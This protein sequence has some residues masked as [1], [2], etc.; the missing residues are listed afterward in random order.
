MCS[1]KSI[2][3]A[4]AIKTGAKSLAA[5]MQTLRR[6]PQGLSPPPI[7]DRTYLDQF[8]PDTAIAAEFHDPGR[9]YKDRSYTST[10][11]KREVSGGKFPGRIR[12]DL[13][14]IASEF[15]DPRRSEIGLIHRRNPKGK[16]QEAN[17][18]PYLARTYWRQ[19]QGLRS[20]STTKLKG[21]EA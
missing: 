19:P 15:R 4:Y 7:S 10:K 16:S 12:A 3:C 6:Q 11:P 13:S 20:R 5:F 18:W 8:A 2:D 14:A 1:V 9:S 21:V 17:S